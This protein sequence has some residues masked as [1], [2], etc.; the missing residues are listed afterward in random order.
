M[1]KFETL[2]GM[3]E[4]DIKNTCLL[5]PLIKKDM[6]YGLGIEKLARGRLYT[7]GNN[8]SFT[9]IHTGV[10]AGLLGDAALYL[11]NTDCQNIIAFGSCGLVDEVD[12]LNIGSLVTPSL[13]YSLESFT[14]MLSGYNKWESYRP[15][16]KLFESLINNKVKKIE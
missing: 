13:S 2:F 7:S 5:L 16:K 15:D 1:T 11:K 6:L 4:T 8:S 14:E 12:D 10:G 3:K 9:I